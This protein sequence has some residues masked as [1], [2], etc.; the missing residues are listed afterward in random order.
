[1]ELPLMISQI[2]PR[3]N[4]TL[5]PNNF[6]KFNP[7]IK[8]KIEKIKSKLK[9]KKEKKNPSPSLLLLLPCTHP[10][11]LRLRGKEEEEEEIVFDPLFSPLSP[12]LLSPQTTQNYTDVLCPNCEKCN[13]TYMCVCVC[14]CGFVVYLSMWVL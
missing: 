3:M 12:V 14:V 8:N 2:R 5:L 13:P 6:I 9:L 4:L 10:Q 1:M 11:N 7:K